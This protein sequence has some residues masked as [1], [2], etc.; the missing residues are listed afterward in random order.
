MD[1]S[2]EIVPLRSS[3]PVIA[4]LADLLIETVASGGSVS[5]MHPLDPS[6]ATSFWTTSLHAADAGARVVLGAMQDDEL[7]GTVTLL[8]DTPPNQPHR[9]EIAKLM[10][11]VRWRRRGIARAL[12]LE[13]I[14]VAREHGRTLL[15]LDTGTDDGAGPL[16][17]QLGFIKAGTIPDYAYKPHGGLQGTTLYWKRLGCSSD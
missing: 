3:P 2:V 15:T 14:R 13:A 4:A 11:R 5:F 16:Y 8:L 17:E 7:I 12:M 9:G 1:A 10:T 6:V